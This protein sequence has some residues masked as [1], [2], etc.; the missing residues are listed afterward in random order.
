MK[1]WFSNRWTLYNECSILTTDEQG[2]LCE[3][4]PD[5]VMFDGEHTVVVDFKF[6][7]QREE[8]HQQVAEY[9]QLLTQM[10]H[11]NVKGY[12]WFVYS[13]QIVEVES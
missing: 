12:L 5:R 7:R 2:N 4:R 11:R 6:G 10:G 1:D 9:M 13:N 3:R 8:Y